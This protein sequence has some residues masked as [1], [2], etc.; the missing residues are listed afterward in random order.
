MS[1]YYDI[2]GH[3]TLLRVPLNIFR[4]KYA[5]DGNDKVCVAHRTPRELQFFI[6]E[7]YET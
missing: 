1:R 6:T 4:S 5:K 7:R 3:S 2:E